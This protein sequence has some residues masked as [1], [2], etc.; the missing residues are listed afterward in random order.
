MENSFNC[1]SGRE[2]SACSVYRKLSDIENQNRDLL[3][4]IAKREEAIHQTTVSPL[5][6]DC[7]T[8]VVIPACR[9]WQLLQGS[10]H[11][12]FQLRLED[13]TRD[14]ESL[15]RQLE[16]ALSDSRRQSEQAREKLSAKV[17]T[18][19]IYIYS[20]LGFLIFAEFCQNRIAK[21]PPRVNSCS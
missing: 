20:T 18:N 14:N 8:C 9:L 13:K 5:N 15:Q 2:N 17:Q 4:T 19:R 3:T 21:I 10:M 1:L 16:A 6:F 11:C 12:I 7:A